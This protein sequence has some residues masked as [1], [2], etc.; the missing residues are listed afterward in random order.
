MKFFVPGTVDEQEALGAWEKQRFECA[1]THKKTFSDDKIFKI[2]YAG[3][4]KDELVK[5]Q[6]GQV[7]WLARE[8][9][10][11]IFGPDD[12]GNPHGMFL[13]A[14]PNNALIVNRDDV[15]RVETFEE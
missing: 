15:V 2:L 11:A 13:V 9:V 5:A 4:G 6:V 7:S 8:R 14:T 10:L 3:T 1:V 12:P